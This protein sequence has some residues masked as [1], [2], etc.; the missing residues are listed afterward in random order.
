MLRATP[1]A[2][3]P[4]TLLPGTLPA[5]PGPLSSATVSPKVATQNCPS[6]SRVIPQIRSLGSPSSAV[7]CSQLPRPTLRNAPWPMLPIQSD[8]SR[9]NMSASMGVADNPPSWCP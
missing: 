8:P 6:R 3:L 9:S 5:L 4:G 1:S 7:Q 2:L